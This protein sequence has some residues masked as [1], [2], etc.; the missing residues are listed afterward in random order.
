M[1]VLPSNAFNVIDDRDKGGEPEVFQQLIDII[2]VDAPIEPQTCT[3]LPILPTAFSYSFPSF[4]IISFI[5]LFN[6]LHY[7][8]F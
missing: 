3:Y 6:S 7:R 5:N 8:T 1:Y 2:Q 4:V